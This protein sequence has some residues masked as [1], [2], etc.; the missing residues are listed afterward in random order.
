MYF[1]EFSVTRLCSLQWTP[2]TLYCFYA[3]CSFLG[4]L[5]YHKP[6][7]PRAVWEKVGCNTTIAIWIELIHN[8]SSRINLTL[9]RCQAIIFV[10]QLYYEHLRFLGSSISSKKIMLKKNQHWTPILLDFYHHCLWMNECAN[11][12]AKYAI[13]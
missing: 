13:N 3:L 1:G 11:P 7:I 5:L 10:K 4:N 9:Y 6:K 12:N 2:D 8:G